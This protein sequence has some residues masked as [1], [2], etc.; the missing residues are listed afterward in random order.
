MGACKN[1]AHTLVVT[2]CNCK[3][4]VYLFNTHLFVNLKEKKEK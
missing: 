4:A 3:Y 2:Y 1:L